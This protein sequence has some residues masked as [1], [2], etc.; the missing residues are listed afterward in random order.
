MPYRHPSWSRILRA[1]CL[2][3]ICW[4]VIEVAYV[5]RALRRHDGTG[6]VGQETV[7]IAS[8]HW[9]NEAVLRSHWTN[10]VL[11]LVKELGP[12]NVFVSIQES[13]SWDDSKGAL[14]I[15]DAHLEDLGVR[16]QVVLEPTT[17]L[18]EI[19]KPPTETGWIR[20]PR[21]K[22][23]LRRI[24]YLARLRNEVME[25]M[26][27]MHA[28]G[29]TFDKILFLNDVVFTP[30][31]VRNL[32]STRNG[33]YAAACSLDFSKPP[34]FYDTF[35]LRDSEGHE[36]LT[37][38]WPFFRSHQSRQA[39][40][41]NSPVPVKSCWNGM[42]RLFAQC[43]LLVSMIILLTPRQSSWTLCRSTAASSV[44]EASRI[45]WH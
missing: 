42:G 36:A 17:H 9:N 31:D 23:E 35:A 6:R 18:D 24:P 16:K 25:P 43:R 37:Q 21:D 14:R 33:E 45:R 3:I 10:A 8:I 26:Y 32:L 30:E 40:K 12:E 7:Y 38:T 41:S 4:T 39:M 27:E 22:V 20:T 44:S 1:F 11:D 15:L 19:N 28:S 5:Q 13:G 2:I 34:R 29:T